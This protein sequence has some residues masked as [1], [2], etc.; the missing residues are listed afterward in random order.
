MYLFDLIVQLRI[1]NSTLT[2]HICYY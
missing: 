2:T 1:W